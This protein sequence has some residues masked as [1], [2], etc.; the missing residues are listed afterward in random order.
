MSLKE[1]A[2]IHRVHRHCRYSNL[3]HQSINQ[4]TGRSKGPAGNTPTEVL[5]VDYRVHTHIFAHYYQ[6]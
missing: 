3:K 1:E 5:R 2:L 6:H 4:G